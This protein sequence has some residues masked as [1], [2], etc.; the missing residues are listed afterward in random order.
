ME[1]HFSIKFPGIE[2][3][4]IKTQDDLR[5][6][7]NNEVSPTL[8]TIPGCHACQMKK[9]TVPGCDLF[10]NQRERRA[11]SHA[12]EVLFSLL[13]KKATDSSSVNDNVEEKNEAVL[14]QMQYAVATGQFKI[15]LQGMNSTAERSSLQHLS[16]N[17]TCGVGYVTSGDRKGCGKHY[18]CQF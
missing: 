8:S 18:F 10:E 3:S 1:H 15:N 13:V 2:C 16:S 4:N 14:F 12:M 6:A 5:S 17:V 9:V 11:V 7:I